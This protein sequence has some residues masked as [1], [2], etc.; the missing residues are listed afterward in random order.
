[1]SRSSFERH[2]WGPCPPP[3]EDE[4]L[5]NWLARA[6]KAHG[7]SG[8]RFAMDRLGTRTLPLDIDRR[9]GAGVMERILAGGRV[10]P[11]QLEEMTLRP[12][13]PRLGSRAVA[14][15]VTP[16]VLA[17]G[18]AKRSRFRHG[19][20]ACLHCLAE[21]SGFRRRWRLAFAVVCDRHA[22]WLV[23][24]CSACDEPLRMEEADVWGGHCRA[25]R[26]AYAQCQGHGPFFS[27]AAQ[28]E[29]WLAHALEHGHSVHLGTARL[30]LADALRGFRFLMRLDH[31][32]V[33]SS[34]RMVE[35]E[36]MRHG[37]RVLYMDR[38]A[39]LL[40][41]W[42][43]G[44]VEDARQANMSRDPFPGEACP[45]WVLEPFSSLRTPRPR[46]VEPKSGEDPVLLHLRR[47]RPANWRSRHAHRLARLIGATS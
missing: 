14:A 3:R 13:E 9:L 11:A 6:A 36:R 32:L 28:L 19:I 30:T 46:R 34:G 47:F 5:S 39:A 1:M 22:S 12:W 43:D 41:R 31:R 16:W 33:G 25:C 20:Q 35:I 29:T 4:L 44:L 23:D 42:P 17:R 40:S 21:G 8:H 38:L 2:V 15:G 24:A 45:S 26:R 18:F 7:Q 10:T 37:E 27:Q